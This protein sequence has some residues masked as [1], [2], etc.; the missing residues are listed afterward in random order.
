LAAFFSFKELQM[1]FK[2]FSSMISLAS[3]RMA[4]GILFV[5]L[6]LAGFGI[7]ILAYPEFFATIAAI[8]FFIIGGSLILTA[9][10]IYIAS[11]RLK[12]SMDSFSQQAQD[13]RENV[14]ISLGQ[15]GDVLDYDDNGSEQ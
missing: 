13:G 6:I 1:S 15:K 14:R 3:R 5:G 9:V 11:W 7:L 2:V 12:K 10:K 4:G 8:I